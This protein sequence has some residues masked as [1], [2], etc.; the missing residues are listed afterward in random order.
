MAGAKIH[1]AQP[2][3][4][5]LKAR[6]IYEDKLFLGTGATLADLCENATRT[7]SQ[8]EIEFEFE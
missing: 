8:G 3:E 2:H 4:L 1:T 6:W 7:T 5:T